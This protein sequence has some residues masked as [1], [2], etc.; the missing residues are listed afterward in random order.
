[1][2]NKNITECKK[3]KSVIRF[4]QEDTFWDES[5]YGYSTKLVKCP[6]C[7]NCII[8]GYESDNW[9]KEHSI[10]YKRVRKTKREKRWNK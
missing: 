10:Y 1:M 3:C 2:K 5:G 7:Q 4:K 9:L 8:L 6:H